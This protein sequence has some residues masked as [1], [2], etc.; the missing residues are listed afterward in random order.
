M[1]RI[2]LSEVEKK[3]YSRICK[4]LQ[5]EPKWFIPAVQLQSGQSF[6]ELALLNNSAR[7]A[8]IKCLEE[9][10][11]AVIDRKNYEKVLGQAEQRRML[12]KMDFFASLSFLSHF[13]KPKL[14]RI[15]PSFYKMKLKRHQVVYHQG[16][17]AEKIFIVKQGEFEVTRK[18]RPHKIQTKAQ[19]KEEQDQLIHKML[20]GQVKDVGHKIKEKRGLEVVHLKNYCTG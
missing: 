1:K 9:C 18:C 12:R 17:P 6:G 8:T 7:A 5:N 16:A 19:R 15:L 20:K 14:N 10:F 2:G 3:K 4:A 13:S 11:F